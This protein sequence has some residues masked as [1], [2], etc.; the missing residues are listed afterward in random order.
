MLRKILGLPVIAAVAAISTAA[1][2]GETV[3]K[4][5][6]ADLLAAMKDEAFS[7]LRYKIFA[8]Q[9]RKNGNTKLAALFEK[10]A[11]DELNKH[12]RA[13]AE[14]LGVAKS[15]KENLAAAISDEYL[16]AARTYSEMAKKAEEAGDAKAAQHFAAAAADEE[17]H[18]QAFRSMLAKPTG[19]AD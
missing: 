10:I 8:E 6:R 4:G 18:R 2:S 16:E 12:F 19:T 11:D 15:D 9:A 13:Q 3:S 1:I 14:I 17:E 7:H 5:T